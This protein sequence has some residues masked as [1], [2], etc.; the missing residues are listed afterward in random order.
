[1]K[2][3]HI[4][5]AISQTKNFEELLE[6]IKPYTL[7]TW[8]G[9]DYLIEDYTT[10]IF[11]IKNALHEDCSAI[12]CTPNYGFRAKVCELI[13]MDNYNLLLPKVLEKDE[14][15]FI[16]L[17]DVTNMFLKNKVKGRDATNLLHLEVNYLGPDDDL[18]VR[19]FMVFQNKDGVNQGFYQIS[20]DYELFS[21]IGDFLKDK[22]D[23]KYQ[24]KSEYIQ[25][26]F[27]NSV[28]NNYQ[29]TFDNLG[30]DLVDLEQPYDV[31]IPNKQKHE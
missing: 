5:Y 4:T 14:C 13:L 26:I 23:M 21:R 11:H 22:I 15:D 3:D 25:K 12:H 24:I 9:C 30:K 17:D 20:N 31:F 18:D 27:T 6:A 1:M 19:L 16:T 8:I 2:I 29:L 28:L 10:N 7:M